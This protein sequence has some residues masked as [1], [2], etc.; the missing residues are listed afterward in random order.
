M[1]ASLSIF[2]LTSHVMMMTQPGPGP[3]PTP[4][5]RREGPVSMA[6]NTSAWVAAVRGVTEGELCCFM[7]V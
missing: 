7:N 1:L 6:G 3:G 4:P 2:I 5:M